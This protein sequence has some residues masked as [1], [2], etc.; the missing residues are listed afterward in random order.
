M[1]SKI[2][3]QQETIPR[4]LLTSPLAP[5]QP[6]TPHPFAGDLYPGRGLEFVFPASQKSQDGGGIEDEADEH[7]QETYRETFGTRF[8]VRCDDFKLR[9][10]A[11]LS[12]DSQEERLS[13]VSV[14][15]GFC[16]GMS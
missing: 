12:E 7:A 13:N 14:L 9:L 10:Q 2:L 11:N 5:R 6:I 8:I 16:V 4:S 3:D 1:S 15:I